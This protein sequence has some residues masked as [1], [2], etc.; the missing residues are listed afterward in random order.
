MAPI[1]YPPLSRQVF[2]IKGEGVFTLT[3]QQLAARSLIVTVEKVIT[4][5]VYDY[6]NFS[7]PEPETQWGYLQLMARD[8]ELETQQL[9]YRRQTVKFWDNPVL[10]PIEQLRCMLR[11]STLLLFELIADTQ[12]VTIIDD[13]SRAFRRAEYRIAVDTPRLIPS[14]ELTAIWYKIDEGRSAFVTIEWEG[15]APIA[16]PFPEPQFVPTANPPAKGESQSS[17]GGTG[18]TTNTRDPGGP[19]Q[20]QQSDPGSDN[21][22]PTPGTNVPE[23][24]TPQ[25]PAP[26]PP[27]PGRWTVTYEN[28]VCV[29]DQSTGAFTMRATVVTRTGLGPFLMLREVVNGSPAFTL[30]GSDGSRV[31]ALSGGG[32]TPTPGCP[33][34]NESVITNQ[35]RLGD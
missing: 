16:C 32:L 20:D 34:P 13:A 4:G 27:A 30:L 12:A 18:G 25:P 1:V 21:P 35:V 8:F 31:L 3:P 15:Y 7:T 9:Q 5:F 11:V 22:G 17:S 28:R 24:P 33:G 29:R 10:D 2:S 14:Q 6:Y 19:P 23:S 26:P